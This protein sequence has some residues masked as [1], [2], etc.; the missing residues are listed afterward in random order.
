MQQ[1]ITN[2]P[3]TVVLLHFFILQI[4]LEHSFKREIILKNLTQKAKIAFRIQSDFL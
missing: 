3:I 2:T 4:I 1:W